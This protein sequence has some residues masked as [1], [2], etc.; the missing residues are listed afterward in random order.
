MNTFKKLKQI[1]PVELHLN[2]LQLEEYKIDRF[3]NWNLRN[4]SKRK[5]ETKKKLQITSKVKYIIFL[6][7]CICFLS[8]FISLFIT[9]ILLIE[10][11]IGLALAT[12][13]L[14]PYEYYKKREVIERTRSKILSLKNLKVIGITGSFGKSSTKDILFHILS[15]KYEVLKTP[16]SYNTI[17][18]VAKVVDIE[19]DKSHEY[20]I[21]EMAA[22]KKG[23]IKNLCYMVPPTYG[24]LT[25]ITTQHFER[26]GS[27]ENT[28]KAKFEL[29]DSIKEKENIIFN[30]N[31]ENVNSEV[32]RRHLATQAPKIQ[33]SNIKF[34]EDGSSFD[35]TYNKKIY[36]ATTPLFGFSNIKNLTL[37]IE[38]ALKLGLSISQIQNTL[39]SLKSTDNRMTLIKGD[40]ATIVN[41]TYSSNVQSF[42]ELIETAKLIPGKKV[43]VTPGI[44]E[45][46]NLEIVVHENLGNLASGVFDQVILVGKNARTNSL[47]NGLDKNFASKGS[48]LFI[49]DTRDEYFNKIEELKNK[50][51]WIFLEND[52]TQNY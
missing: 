31:D 40:G 19:L 20:F 9:L 39:K 14:K 32:K 23:E 29:I 10:P 13:I 1:F 6:Y 27:L 15:S 43:L 24:I 26:F 50:F 2:I 45:L 35:L 4:L 46:G 30:F 16:E 47:A 28:I 48:Y 49:E 5:L 22:Y 44:V 8:I 42:K 3:L 7:M 12:L 21:C 52:L 11:F 17:F 34:S 18:G 33:I 51:N 38:M 36:K 25:G 41:N 37:A